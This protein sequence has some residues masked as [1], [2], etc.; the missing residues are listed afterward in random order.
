[1]Y[2]L[3]QEAGIGIINSVGA[4]SAIMTSVL[5]FLFYGEKLNK[6]QWLGAFITTAGIIWLF[7]VI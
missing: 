2:V 6:W 7:Q 1:M 4:S 3:H 5:A